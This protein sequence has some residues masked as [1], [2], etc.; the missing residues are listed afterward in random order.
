MFKQASSLSLVIPVHNE[1]GNLMLL[2]RRIR[3]VMSSMNDR[4]EVIYVDDGS[5]DGSFS[6]LEQL[7]A[8]DLHVK[9]VGL[10]R[11]FGQTA[12][13]AAGVAHSRGEVLILLDADLQNDPADIPRLLVKLEEGYDLVSG[14]RRKR[15]GDGWLRCL[16]SRLAN[17]LAARAAGIPIHDLGC[18]LKVYRRAVFAHV[19]LYGEMHRFLAAYAAL[20]GARIAEVEVRHHPRYAGRSHYG[21]DRTLRVLLD[22]LLLKF[23]RS[24]ATRPQQ[25]LGLP[26]LLALALGVAFLPLVLILVLLAGR[27]RVASWSGPLFLGVLGAC[28][29]GLL[30]LQLGVLAEM[31]MRTYYESQNKQPY[32]VRCLVSGTERC[33]C[34]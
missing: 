11:N 6:V 19:P 25:L 29:F 8:T 1:M 23:Y 3:D 27:S 7:A 17:F 34:W 30:S 5:T 21:L 12:A 13:L 26:G 14:W 22:L 4:Y 24:F 2:H 20:A 16:L 33:E 32:V 18:T 15:Q 28:C 9:V 31:L 10:S